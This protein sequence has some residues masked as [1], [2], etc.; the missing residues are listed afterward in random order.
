MTPILS[1]EALSATSGQP[2]TEMMTIPFFAD[3]RKA[4]GLPLANKKAAPS[5]GQYG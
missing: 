5:G 4:D 3:C 1:L 2:S